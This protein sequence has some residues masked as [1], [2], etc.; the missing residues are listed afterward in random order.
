MDRGIDRSLDREQQSL[1]D[2]YAYDDALL[3]A[4]RPREQRARDQSWDALAAA[5]SSELQVERADGSTLQLMWQTSVLFDTPF[6]PTWTTA[7]LP[8]SHPRLTTGSPRRALHMRRVWR[9]P[10]WW[11]PRRAAASRPR[12]LRS[13]S[14]VAEPNCT[15]PPSTSPPALRESGR[16]ESWVGCATAMTSN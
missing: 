11:P 9:T 12:T 7:R 1:I 6:Q 2:W 4:L 15:P 10:L 14:V 8:L 3:L 16:C 13:Q 5:E